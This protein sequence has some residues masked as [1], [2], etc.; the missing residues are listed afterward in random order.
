MVRLDTLFIGSLLVL[1]GLAFLGICV[2]A[3]KPNLRNTDGII[4]TVILAFGCI[5][6]LAGAVILEGL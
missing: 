4:D 5:F 6:V 3:G 2:I 1:I